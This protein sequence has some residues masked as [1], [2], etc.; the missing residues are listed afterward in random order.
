LH[1]AIVPFRAPVYLPKPANVLSLLTMKPHRFPPRPAPRSREIVVPVTIL[2][3]AAQLLE[4]DGADPDRTAR[5][6]GLD[7]VRLRN[8]T[9]TIGF[10]EIGRYVM[11]CVRASRDDTFP[12]RLGLAEGPA[13]LNAIGYMAQHSPD[14]RSSL[15]TLRTYGHIYAGGLTLSRERGLALV[16]Y[17][18]LFP[19]IE[20]AGPMSEA[21][22]GILVSVLRQL[23]G[24]AWNPIEVR[25]SR[26][27]P[28]QPSKWRQ[29]IGAP[30]T[31]GAEG[32]LVVFSAKWLDQPVERADPELRRILHDRV[33]E[34]DAEHGADLPARVC[35]VIRASLLT[36][37]VSTRNVANRLAVSERTLRRRLTG[38]ESSF[39]ALLDRTRFEVACHLLENSAASITQI[40]DLLGYAHSSALSRAFRR[41]ANTSPRDWRA[42]RLAESRRPSRLPAR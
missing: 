27:V 1:D 29:C 8:P 39:E 18:F 33:A 31:F 6:A 20:G 28:P 2:A 16:E 21:A 34:L 5:A 36:G 14:V 10:A 41:W 19:R 24:P 25:M 11:E 32:N 22:V 15:E 26:R 3:S 7:P 17:K 23:C 30:V 13:A 4:E 37:D 9:E 12:L 42:G 38:E 35:S 40:A